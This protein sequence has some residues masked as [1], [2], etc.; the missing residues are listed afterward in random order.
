MNETN[1]STALDSFSLRLPVVAT[2]TLGESN[3]L[4]HSRQSSSR[5]KEPSF[6]RA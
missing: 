2:M 5:V 4:T 6:W 1:F 3:Q